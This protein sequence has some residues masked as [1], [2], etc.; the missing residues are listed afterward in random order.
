MAREKQHVFSARTTEE[1]LKALN[2]VKSCFNISWDELVIDAVSARYNLDKAM[3]SLPRKEKPAIE[4]PTEQPPTEPQA[5]LETTDEPA[6][7]EEHPAE[8]TEKKPAKKKAKG[9]KK[10]AHQKDA[11]VG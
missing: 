2:E 4:T 6:L 9:D 10:G 1:G 7:V 3:M 5:P 8:P 11:E